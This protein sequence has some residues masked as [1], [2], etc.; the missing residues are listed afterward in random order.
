MGSPVM[1]YR[2]LGRSGLN[3]SVVGI[4]TTQLRR[5]PEKQAIET[6]VKAFELG[7]N[8]V[9]T[10]PD[11]EGADDLIARA[12]RE[13]DRQV[14]VTI[15]TAGSVSDVE[16]VFEDAC[17][18]FGPDRIGLF[19]LSALSEQVVFGHDVWGPHGTVEFLRRKREEGRLRALYASDHGSPEQM[20]A[21]LERDVFDVLMLAYNP[22]GFHLITF[23]PETVWQIES[24]P[25]PLQGRY[26][27]EDIARTGSEVLPMARA[28]DVGIMVMKPFAGGLL[29]ASKA[30]PR[31]PWRP[32][33]PAPLGARDLLRFLLMDDAVSCVVPGTASVDEAVENANA[34]IGHIGLDQETADRIRA[35]ARA[36]TTTLCSRCGACDDLCSRGLPVSFLFRAAYN[37]LY[38]SAPFEISSGLQYFKLHP[39]ERALCETCDNRTCRCVPG[40]DIPAEMI[41]IHRK[42]VELRDRG[43]VPE[44]DVAPASFAAG[45]PYAARLLSRD[46]PEGAPAGETATVR[47]H[48]RNTGQ[49]PWFAHAGD[50]RSRVFLSVRLDGR[51]LPD[52]ALRHDVWPTQQCHFAFEVRVAGPGTHRLRLDLVD[53][54]S[55]PF[56]RLGNEP[57]EIAFDAQGGGPSDT[58]AARPR[59]WLRSMLS[60]LGGGS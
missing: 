47:L 55:G 11:Y 30:F 53:E 17:E 9:N 45:G 37:Y 24:P 28:R 4:G 3:V 43:Q 41:A 39:G 2:R 44:A 50:G 15:Q 40:I 12:L 21:L 19:G 60:S 58:W 31:R 57:M 7:V 16:R 49:H 10:G 52:V 46:V 26:E 56:S 59:A 34:G 27:W 5:V 1:N 38:P 48:V 25:A 8:H 29:T 23:R 20:K 35:Q 14:Y 54:S 33:L 22:L 13:T 18:T 36:M 42:M 51:A 32:G 6:L